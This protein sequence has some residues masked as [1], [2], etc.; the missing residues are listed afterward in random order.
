MQVVCDKCHSVLEFKGQ[1]PSFCGYCGQALSETQ[2]EAPLSDG[3]EAPTVAPGS[4][5]P[6][7]HVPV[8]GG[9]RLLRSL[10][11]GG[12]GTVYEA[13]EAASGR[14]VALKLTSAS[15]ATSQLTVERFHQEGRLASMISHPRC[16]FVQAVGE[17]DG[18]PF[19][20]MELMPGATLKD[21]VDR[22]G[23]L[24][25]AD[26]V[27]KTLD[28]IAGLQ[29]AHRCDVI[30]RDVKPS[31]CFLELDGR[32]KVGDFGLAKSLG[33]G[34]HL[35]KT[36][37]FLGT[38]HFA[39][40]EQVR[41]DPIDA[42]TDVY[43]VA[44]T[45][46]YLLTA[47]PP[48]LGP[49]AAATLARIV[50]D[51]PPS[52]RSLRP[53]VPAALERVVLRGLERERSLR[54]SDLESLRRA[55]VPFL[56]GCLSIGS[57]GLR[58]AAFGIDCLLVVVAALLVAALLPAF[59][60]RRLVTEF[61]AFM[62]GWF[63]LA[64]TTW[65]SGCSVGKRL[66]GLR[67]CRTATSDAPCLGAALLRAG[68]LLAL[69]FVGE[70]ATTTWSFF[71]A[72]NPKPEAQAQREPR[73]ASMSFPPAW[74]ALGVV[75]LAS[76]MSQGKGY[77]GLHEVMSGT[78]VVELPKSGR[79]RRQAGPGGWLLYFLRS[80]RLSQGALTPAGLPERL[81]RFTVRGA[82]R[83][84]AEEKILFGDDA[85]LGRKVLIWLRPVDAAPLPA[86][87]R[88]IS[89]ITRLRWVAE[90]AHRDWLWNA[91]LVPAG[92]P[93]PEIIANE[94][95]LGWSEARPLLEQLT[96]EVVAATADGTVP[97]SLTTQQV[98][99]QE[100]GQLQLTDSPLTDPAGRTA[101]GPLPAAPQARALRLLAEVALLVL[102]GKPRRPD[103]EPASIRMPLPLHARPALDRL[104]AGNY[105]AVP[106]FQEDL[107]AT[108]GRPTEISRLQRASQLAI[109]SLLLCVGCLLM[110]F[111]P[112]GLLAR[113]FQGPVSEPEY[114]R[115]VGAAVAA[116]CL[117]PVLWV[118]AAF[119][120]RGGLALGGAGMAIVGSDGR[121][122]SR[123]R[124]AGRAFWLS[125]PITAI[126]FLSMWMPL[127]IDGSYSLASFHKAWQLCWIG[128]TIL[129][130]ICGALAVATPARTLADRLA[131]TWLVPI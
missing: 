43:S 112:F 87:R 37:S 100:D 17:E 19:I 42:Q 98:W 36:G 123:L 125:A 128:I 25:P 30:H 65:W 122:V 59:P 5:K 62:A 89:R 88:D 41:G 4:A 101:S 80:R 90:G 82:L 91:F 79:P 2:S 86:T 10:G 130:A 96:A 94:G 107:A 111:T 81:G 115:R 127:W 63:Y 50:T 85:A 34:A 48:F 60:G 13:E 44:A 18:R 105:D 72:P 51:P 29:E 71:D 78:R 76:T 7:D 120:F 32:V 21:L 67:I 8:I 39:S 95:N 33:G 26:A 56:P 3:H 1:P 84:T 23:P 15:C 47:R 12:M 83:W 103:D 113:T 31:N 55:L 53:E 73:F 99:V 104:V 64:L 70:L 6:P 77:R 124:C 129:L 118:V 69:L 22:Q 61:G 11:A 66:L 116:S 110:F 38:P 54:W 114:L 108:A 27:A 20:V 24:A 16:V 93:L 131:A 119:C 126:L 121:P 46:F 97:E 74:L 58:M 75:L 92:T 9:Y 68:F 40:P 106:Q 45:L 52:L 57:L 28:V 35:T 117:G 109:L 49:D 14:R 102:E